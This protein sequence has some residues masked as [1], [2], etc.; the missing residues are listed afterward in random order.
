MHV[1]VA[2]A[3]WRAAEPIDLSEVYWLL[4]E[5]YMDFIT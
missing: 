5:T 2:S 1:P 4:R 3:A